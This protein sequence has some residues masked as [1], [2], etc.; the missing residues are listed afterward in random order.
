M[1]IWLVAAMLLAGCASGPFAAD[2]DA[3]PAARPAAIVVSSNPLAAEAGAEILR[4]GGNAI[5]AAAAVALALTVVEPHFSGIG[6]GG[7]LLYRA[8]NGTT[9]VLDGRETAPAAATPDMFLL[10][11]GEPMH[12]LPAHVRGY[13]VGVP[14]AVALWDEAL[15]AHGTLSWREVAEPARRLAADG[16]SVD[17]YLAAYLAQPANLAKLHSWPASAAQMYK[18]PV[19]PPQVGLPGE[20]APCAPGQ[21]YAEGETLRQADLARTL[22]MLQEEGA[23]AF[24]HGEIAEAIVA[25]T[26]A[27]EGRMT[28]EDL[29]A[30]EVVTREPLSLPYRGHTVVSMP[31]PGGGVVM[32]Q[33]LGILEPLDLRADGHHSGAALHKVIEAQHLAYADRGAY[34]GDPAFVDV[35]TAGMLHQDY[36]AERRALIGERANADVRPGD[37]GGRREA[38]GSDADLHTASHTSH[39][40]VVDHAGNVASATVTIESIF[41]SGMIVP[42]YGF[43]LNNEMTDFDFEPGGANEVAPGKRPRSAMSPTI[44]LGPEGAP[45]LVA[46][47]SGGP[48]IISSVFQVIH[49]VLEHELAI[50]EALASGRIYSP[51]HTTGP[52]TPFDVRWDRDVPQAA[53]DDLRA[54][55][56]SPEPASSGTI[57]QAEAALL[58]DGAWMGAADTRS[59]PGGVVSVPAGR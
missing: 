49:N 14:G 19:C 3:A 2:P 38:Q 45:S 6:G 21:P 52:T 8:A 57:S 16:F 43:F 41:G 4:A 10:P 35:P 59:A 20:P 17:A 39:L 47:A 31:P 5:D 23:D 9:I 34:L 50:E 30:Y 12:F 24:Y 26:S 36:L 27:R 18:G 37:P 28:T 1:R 11:T 56:H 42:G 33:M 55:G 22:A 48:T 44:V 40:L 46:G 53:R 15:R 58:V 51:A 25:A 32:L 13:A 29:A 54:R 7:F